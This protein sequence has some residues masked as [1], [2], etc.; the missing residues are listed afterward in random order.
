MSLSNILNQFM[1]SPAAPSGQ[2]PNQG[3]SGDFGQTVS[4]LASNIPGGLVGRAAA[5]GAMAL[6][7]GNKSAR[8]FAGKTATIG[9]TALLGGL[10]FKAYQNWQGNNSGAASTATAESS[11][12]IPQA[13]TSGPLVSRRSRVSIL[14][15]Y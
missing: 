6:L 13:S 5:V 12:L 1:G 3:N 11:P 8:K 9:G 10:A 14:I 2:E 15:W 7:M 4:N